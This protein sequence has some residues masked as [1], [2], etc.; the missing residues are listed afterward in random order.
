MSLAKLKIAGGIAILVGV[1]ATSAV[2]VAQSGSTP[3]PASAPRGAE[4]QNRRVDLR[5]EIHAI[6]FA[7]EQ[8][9]I[10]WMNA[11]RKAKTPAELSRAE[12]DLATKQKPLIERC[13]KMVKQDP[14]GAAGLIALKMVACRSPK[15]DE[16][17]KAAEALIAKAASADLG[18][19]AKSLDYPTNVSR[20]STSC[21]R[22]KPKTN[23]PSDRSRPFRRVATNTRIRTIQS[24][25]SGLVAP[26][27]IGYHRLVSKRCRE[28]T[29]GPGRYRETHCVRDEGIRRSASDPSLDDMLAEAG[30]ACHPLDLSVKP[31]QR[32]LCEI[33]PGSRPVAAEAGEHGTGRRRWRRGDA[34]TRRRIASPNSRRAEINVSLKYPDHVLRTAI[35]AVGR[36]MTSRRRQEFVNLRT[37]FW[38]KA[39]PARE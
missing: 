21:W 34:A 33:M 6:K 1:F 13:L 29:G 28:A 39:D 5:D 17:K 36:T 8:A 14:D 18:V 20:R 32:P 2:V 15:T 11:R 23:R 35:A 31:C 3:G 26:S 7:W 25:Q 27:C 38:I 22:A 37:E 24:R 4:T 12:I 30:R 19:L 10:E 9:L 16:G